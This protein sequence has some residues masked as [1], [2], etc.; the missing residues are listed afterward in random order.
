[1][2]AALA[3]TW[4]PRGELDR[5]RAMLDDLRALYGAVIVAL[6]PDVSPDIT[7]S[8][9]D[10]PGVEPLT[11]V[12]WPSARHESVRRALAAGAA[13]V[14]YCDFDRLLHWLEVFPA[15]LRDVV[16]RID[17]ADCVVLGRTARAWETH[18]RCMAET[19]ALFNVA[20]SHLLGVESWDFGAGSRTFRREAAVFLLDHSPP[21]DGW[22]ID[23]AWPLMLAR[24]G[25]EVAYRAV[26]GLEWETPDQRR[27]A[28]APDAVRR[29]MAAAWDADPV[30]WQ[31]RVAV[32]DAI[33]RVGIRAAARI[34][35]SPRPGR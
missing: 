15:E 33:M 32:A 23:A 34:P 13:G 31:Q 17:R 12:D 19:E 1:V 25:Y 2:R 20:F 6:P 29:A 30:R 10:L 16:A 22:A 3:A 27:G 4:V 26:D 7:Q 5:L 8:L 11:G 21:E 9:N 18:P 24:S 14:Q 28:V 35:A